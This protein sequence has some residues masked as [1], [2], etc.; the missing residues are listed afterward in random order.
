METVFLPS[1]TA[2]LFFSYTL[3]FLCVFL[4]CRTLCTNVSIRILSEACKTNTSP[5]CPCPLDHLQPL[6][7]SQNGL[8]CPERKLN[9]D[10]LHLLTW[11]RRAQRGSTGIIDFESWV[12]PLYLL[13]FFFFDLTSQTE[14][15]SITLT[16]TCPSASSFVVLPVHNR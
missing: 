12:K 5:D 7:L 16:L 2:S 4:S 8:L 3:F 1:L 10:K 13:H 11:H 6:S 15:F 9:T 14:H